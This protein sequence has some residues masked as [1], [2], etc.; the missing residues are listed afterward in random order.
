MASSKCVRVQDKFDYKNL[1]EGE[2]LS[3]KRFSLNLW[4]TQVS[5]NKSSIKYDVQPL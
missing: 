5:P 1:N 4:L 3:L 2:A